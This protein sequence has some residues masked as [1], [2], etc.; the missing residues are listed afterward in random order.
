MKFI[1]YHDLMFSLNQLASKDEQIR[2]WANPRKASSYVEAVE[3]VYGDSYL[4]DML[5]TNTTGLGPEIDAVLIELEK[6][7]DQVDSCNTVEMIE[8]P[9][10]EEIRQLA[11]KAYKLLEPL[12]PNPDEPNP[13]YEL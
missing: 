13:Y 5:K 7:I 9:I 1:N 4:S 12:N 11:A 10:M 2:L 6:K 8:K 3:V